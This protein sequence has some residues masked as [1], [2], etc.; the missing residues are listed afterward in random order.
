MARTSTII[1]RRNRDLEAYY[2]NLCKKYPHW[3]NDFVIEKVA[4]KFY[5]TE[6]TTYAIL[7]GQYGAHRK[8]KKN[9]NE[10]P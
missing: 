8:P 1:E 6:R 3:K 10:K 4:Y 2:N 5:L 9:T 7:S